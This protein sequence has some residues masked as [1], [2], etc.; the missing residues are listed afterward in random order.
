MAIATTTIGSRVGLHARPAAL[1]AR[2][3]ADLPV[4]VTI[5]LGDGEPVD[6]SSMLSVMTLG[7]A[8]GD[9]VTLRAD[10]DG[11]DAALGSLAELLAS[12]LDEA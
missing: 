2:A 9:S 4:D 12:E 10:G 11:A 5:A 7:A 8:F 6:A 1:F 3:A